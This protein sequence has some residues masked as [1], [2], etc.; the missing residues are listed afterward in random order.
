[1]SRDLQPYQL[2]ENFLTTFFIYFKNIDMVVSPYTACPLS[3]LYGYSLQYSNLSEG[4]WKEMMAG[5]YYAGEFLPITSVKYEGNNYSVIPYIQS[6]PM[7]Q[8]DLPASAIIML[9][10]ATQVR[11]LLERVKVYDRGWVYVADPQGRIITSISGAR[12]RVEIVDVQSNGAVFERRVAGMHMTVIHTTSGRNGWRYVAVLPSAAVMGRVRYV[13]NLTFGVTLFSM[14]IGLLVAYYLAYRNTKP[15][16]EIVRSLTGLFDGKIDR[17]GTEYEVLRGTLSA[18]KTI[19]TDNKS[20][21]HAAE[22]QRPLLKAAVIDCLLKGS[23]RNLAE[24]ES[25]FTQVGWKIKG[26]SFTVM[27]VRIAGNG[28][29]INGESLTELGYIKVIVEDILTENISSEAYLHYID[30]SRFA[31]LLGSSANNHDNFI[32]ENETIIKKV[33]DRLFDGYGVKALCAL[34]DTCTNLLDICNSYDQ[35]REASDYQAIKEDCDIVWYSNLPKESG[36]YY[37]PMELERRLVFLTRVGGQQELKKLLDN[38]YLENFVKRELSVETTQQLLYEL[39]GTVNRAIDEDLSETINSDYYNRLK[40]SSTVEDFFKAM[41]EILMLT[42]DRSIERNIKS[43]K[44]LIE[45]VINYIR[46]NFMHDDLCLTTVSSE[47][48]LSAAYLS[49]LFKEETGENFS[50]CLEKIRMERASELLADPG[51]PIADIARQ[52]GYNSDKVFRRAFKRV[53]GASPTD[54]RKAFRQ[55]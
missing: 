13:R 16:K 42:C 17:E 46:L 53:K 37:Y 24:I 45:G 52:L 27:I 49:Q 12:A 3:S 44:H 41:Q 10:D 31:V 32:Q 34:G 40:K 21:L 2:T 11:K 47:F 4:Q 29:I 26:E 38:I 36:H 1:M 7:G 28:T 9:I 6:L 8:R 54:F 22:Q 51:L 48:R 23:Y 15:L 50:D 33:M 25:A 14:L 30:Q 43:K 35:A 55:D 5:R 18:I 39:R 20:L 19:L